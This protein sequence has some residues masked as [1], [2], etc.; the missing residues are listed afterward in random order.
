M[1]GAVLLI[2]TRLFRLL[3]Q[4]FGFGAALSPFSGRALLAVLLIC[5]C[6]LCLLAFL[7]LFT[8]L[9]LF[10]LLCS[11]CVL[12]CFAV[13]RCFGGLFGSTFL[14]AFF[15]CFCFPAYGSGGIGCLLRQHF[16]FSILMNTALVIIDRTD[17]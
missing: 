15:A 5:F 3:C 2:F 14:P 13:S 17:A 1:G 7:C 4:G 9:C 12:I 16:L 11:V 6:F 8:F 10:I